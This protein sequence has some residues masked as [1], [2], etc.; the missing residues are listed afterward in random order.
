MIRL[1]EKSRP[2][3]CPDQPIM[4]RQP[5]TVQFGTDEQRIVLDQV[6]A[7]DVRWLTGLDG[8]K[9][10][11]ELAGASITDG[12][13]RL[14]DAGLRSGAIEDA[15]RIADSWRVLPAPQ[16]VKH[17]GD[18]AAT[19]LTYRSID[20]TLHAIERRLTLRARIV[21]AGPVFEACHSLMS[22]SGIAIVEEAADVVLLAGG[23]HPD[24]AFAH[25]SLAEPGILARPHIYI[26][27]YGAI[28][29]VGPLVVPG[30]TS[31]LMCHQRHRR[32]GDPA[33]PVLVTQRMALATT[34]PSW[35]IDGLHAHAVASH[36][37]LLL[38]TWREH[39]QARHLWANLARC[40][41]LPDGSTDDVPRPMHPLCGCTWSPL[42]APGGDT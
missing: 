9:T 39:P 12:Q 1:A 3:Y 31:C 4:W 35:P 6:N 14:L 33:W 8:L 25:P 15:G 28:G 16:R 20:D 19:R 24:A 38:R 11:A 42:S 17:H 22:P 26:G 13:R 34:L 7:A 5:G 36:A 37:L 27:A 32:D 21:G 2:R 29:V 30:Q 10:W 40:I 23:V 41:W 18:I